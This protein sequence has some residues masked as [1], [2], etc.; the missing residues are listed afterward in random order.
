MHWA[1]ERGE[2]I[3]GWLREDVDV[4][5]KTWKCRK[6]VGGSESFEVKDMVTN[7]DSGTLFDLGVFGGYDSKR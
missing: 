3:E 1:A 7:C 5:L 6:A 4:L 2:G